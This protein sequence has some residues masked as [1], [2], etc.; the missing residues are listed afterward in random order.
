MAFRSQI[1]QKVFHF[2]S[3][4]IVAVCAATI[5][6]ANA[7]VTRYN[8]LCSL[9]IFI[10]ILTSF[11]PNGWMNAIAE[12]AATRLPFRHHK[13]QNPNL[14]MLE[15][16]R[17]QQYNNNEWKR[18]HPSKYLRIAFITFVLYLINDFSFSVVCGCECE[19]H[20]NSVEIAKSNLK[21]ILFIVCCAP[22]ILF[23]RFGKSAVELD[24]FR[25]VF[26]VTVLY[27]CRCFCYRHCHHWHRQC[28]R[29]EGT[30]KRSAHMLRHSI[31]YILKYFVMRNV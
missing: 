28:V 21:P 6:A 29:I 13:F 30:G 24:K 14:E 10:I 12:W 26:I 9:L 25:W 15:C 4:A 17:L 23:E 19:I 2:Y 20:I 31:I 8:S 5:T 18:Q 7:V 3:G 27:Y 16:V 11:L 22:R 1:H